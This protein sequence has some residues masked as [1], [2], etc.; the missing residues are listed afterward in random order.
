M[1]KPTVT[2]AIEAAKALR[3]WADSEANCF[4]ATAVRTLLDYTHA[5]RWRFGW[6]LTDFG[7]IVARCGPPES[8]D[9]LQRHYETPGD[10][11]V[12]F[13]REYG[14]DGANELEEQFKLTG[15]M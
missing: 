10:A 13:C 14:G 4:P 1:S 6:V 3:A 2:D 15:L 7:C 9:G 11:V 8:F 12:A 5:D